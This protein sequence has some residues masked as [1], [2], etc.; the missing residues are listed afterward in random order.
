MALQQMSVVAFERISATCA[1]GDDQCAA[2]DS[3]HHFG[4]I[5]FHTSVQLRCVSIG[6]GRHATTN[7][8]G[9][10]HGE[11]I[12]R[13]QIDDNLPEARI[14]VA[15]VTAG[16]EQY[17]SRAVIAKLRADRGRVIRRQAPLRRKPAD[18]RHESPIRFE[19]QHR[20]RDRRDARA[21]LSQNVLGRA[22]Q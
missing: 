3:F 11:A 22:S 21:E 4:N 12:E 14:V 16:E 7:V 19:V 8:G 17:R 5:F 20:V 1:R 18:R 2:I 6:D 10:I 9:D 15:D 13:Q